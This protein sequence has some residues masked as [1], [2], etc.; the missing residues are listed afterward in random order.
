LGSKAFD[1]KTNSYYDPWE[2][3]IWDTVKQIRKWDESIPFYFIVDDDIKNIS[4]YQNF[5]NFSVTPVNSKFLKVDTDLS[6]LNYFNSHHDPLWKTS[7]YRFFYINFLIKDK[8]LENIISFDNDVLIYENLTLL[9]DKIQSIYLN[10]C[11]TP[12]MDTELVCGFFWVKNSKVLSEINDQL[13]YFAKNPFDYHPTEMK[14]LYKIQQSNNKLI[15]NLPIWPEG[16][17]ST[18]FNFFNSIFDP[19][20][21]SQYLAGCNNGQPPGTILKHHILGQEIEKQKFIIKES[22]KDSKKCFMLV[23]ENK[24]IPINSLHM[25]RKNFIKKFI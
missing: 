13:I 8:N 19:C 6:K 7:L 21:I 22:I 3:H 9:N 18:N 14:M 24:E 17:Y 23:G 4:N 10:S 16:K 5:D 11:I 15:E 12:V 20:T 2:S 1:P 25:H